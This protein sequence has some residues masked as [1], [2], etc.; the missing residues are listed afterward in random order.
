MK[1]MKMI[2]R[3][4][5]GFS[6]IEALIAVVILSVG[7]LAI[8]VMQITAMKS[9]TNALSRGDGVAMAQSVMDILRCVPLDDGMLTD[10]DTTTANLD[11]GRAVGNNAPVAA[12]AGHQGD[13][14]FA[15]NPTLGP[16]GLSYNIFWNVDEDVPLTGTRTVRLFVYWNDQRFGRNKVVITSVLG[17]LYL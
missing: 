7:L 14:V 3:N 9:N 11:D 15:S 8:G 12:N 1:I 2:I 16:N 10:S 5:R 13:E 4:Q 6:L 17:G